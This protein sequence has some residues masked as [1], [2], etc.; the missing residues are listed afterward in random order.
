MPNR[1]Q[2]GHPCKSK[3]IIQWKSEVTRICC[4]FVKVLEIALRNVCIFKVQKQ[5]SQYFEETHCCPVYIIDCLVSRYF[6]LLWGCLE[7]LLS[8]QRPWSLWS[9][10]DHYW[11]SKGTI[12]NDRRTTAWV[13]L[14][15]HTWTQGSPTPAISPLLQHLLPEERRPSAM[16]NTLNTNIHHNRSMKLKHK[17]KLRENKIK[18]QL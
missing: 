17:I 13:G 4:K 1:P 7:Y 15:W 9:P 2:V 6:D 12:H 18:L 5:A 3:G 14:P 16:S 8:T 11:E 10:L